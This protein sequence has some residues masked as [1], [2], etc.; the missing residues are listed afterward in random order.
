MLNAAYVWMFGR[1]LPF[2]FVNL[3]YIVSDYKLE[4]KI[5]SNIESTYQLCLLERT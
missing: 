3:S 5:S 4:L 1:F 2:T